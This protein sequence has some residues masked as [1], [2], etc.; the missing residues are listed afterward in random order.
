MLDG[1]SMAQKSLKK[2]AYLATIGSRLLRGASAIHATAE[3]ESIQSK[4]WAQ[5][6]RWSVIPC[7]FDS[8]PYRER[9]DASEAKHTF[10]E[11]FETG[12]PV[13]LFLSRVHPGKGV[14][15]LIDAVAHL[16]DRLPVQCVIAGPAEKA[17]QRELETQAK[18]AGV[19]ERIR[20]VGFVGGSLKNSLLAAADAYVLASAHENF[21]LALAEAMACGT[22]VITTRNVGPWREL[23]AAGAWITEPDSQAIDGA[24]ENILRDKAAASRSAE[25]ARAWILDA[26]DPRKTALRY[27]ELYD[28]INNA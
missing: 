13:V 10:P 26:W 6:T 20:F 2:R 22:P 14:P 27:L 18:R 4:R 23:E 17:F 12:E 15:E 11:V 21:G 24:L 5:A 7:V 8:D 28:M 16:R 1:W 3:A 9:P 19:A 25:R